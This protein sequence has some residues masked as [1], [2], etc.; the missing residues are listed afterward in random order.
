MPALELCWE[1]GQLGGDSIPA[2]ELSLPFG[3]RSKSQSILP[4]VESHP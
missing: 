1:E 2:Q 4:Y 3:G